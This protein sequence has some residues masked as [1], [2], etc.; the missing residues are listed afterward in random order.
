MAIVLQ[1]VFVEIVLQK[2]ILLTEKKSFIENFSWR[3]AAAKRPNFRFSGG[4]PDS[5]RYHRRTRP[6]PSL[7]PVSG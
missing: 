6:T 3:F 2:P 5:T 7:S 4:E 1:V